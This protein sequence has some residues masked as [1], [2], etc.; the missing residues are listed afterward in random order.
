MTQPRPHF[1]STRFA[2]LL[3]GLGT[4]IGA[5]LLLT[6]APFWL[7]YLAPLLTVPITIRALHV[8]QSSKREESAER[9]T[10]DALTARPGPIARS[11]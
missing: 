5:I 2:A 9:S 8:W 4:L 3:L 1:S 11:H 6:N 10:F 7:F